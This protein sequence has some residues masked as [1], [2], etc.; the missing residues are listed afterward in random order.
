LCKDSALADAL[1]T[2]LFCMSYE[3]GMKLIEKFENTEALWVLK[4]GTK[5]YSQD[6]IT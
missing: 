5:K 4:D 3:D 6:F 2:T 1:S